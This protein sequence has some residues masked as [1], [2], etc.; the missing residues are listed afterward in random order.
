MLRRVS[1]V[2]LALVAGLSAP[3]AAQL[4][5][6]GH[7][8]GAIKV[9][10]Q[11]LAIAVD[12]SGDTGAP[13]ATIDIPQQ[14][15]KG[16]G[17]MNVR[18]NDQLVHF[19]LPAGP[20]LAVFDGVLRGE[21]ISGTFE[22]GPMK[23][24]FELKKTVIAQEPPPPYKQEEVKI[25]NG[26]ITLA[27]TLTLPPRPGPH[28]A[29]VLITGSGAQNR[30]EEVF[31][32]K[33]FK[34][35]ADNITR[36]GIAV[37]RCDDRGVG[38]STGSTPD[39]TTADFAEDVLAEV[40]FLKGRQDID[41]ARIGLLGHSEGGIIAPMVATRSPDVAFIVLMSGPALNGEK[42]MLA[43]NELIGRAE[44]RTPE[45]IKSNT[46]V[47]QLLFAAARQNRGWDEATLAV[48]AEIRASI[49][50]LPEA[51]RKAIPD[52]ERLVNAQAEGQIALVRSPW[53]RFFLDY[54]PAPTLAR[55]A[56]PVL[57]IFGERD[58]QVAAEPNRAVMEEIAKKGAARDFTI[59]VIPGA[60]HLYQ[61]ATTGSASEY[62]RLKKE[63]APGFAELVVSWLAQHT[64][65]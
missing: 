2:A 27:G 22:Q 62:A 16:L 65:R 47:Q 18:L 7:W 54:D 57:A 37:L 6:G 14:G 56:C 45:Q 33:V 63:F 3:A 52:V 12:I 46:R 15:A 5:A 30:D 8:E 60:N 4:P 41:K 44:G 32:F 59:K 38:G 1:I 9:V 64:K 26:G 50:Q 43:Q 21:T 51:Q 55:V 31:G 40:K 48:K 19:E 20:G 10:G 35:L 29:V 58:L 24:T 23:G 34:L 61:A 28:P 53:F 25:T 36:A 49:Q 11:E 13:K 17:L 39:S 42:I